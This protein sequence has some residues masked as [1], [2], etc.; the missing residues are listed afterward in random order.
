MHNPE[1]YYN[2]NDFTVVEDEIFEDFNSVEISE[3]E[4]FGSKE[5]ED[6]FDDEIFE[7][8]VT[9][10][11]DEGFDDEDESIDSIETFLPGIGDDEALTK[12]TEE[13]N[14]E[15][16]RMSESE[17]MYYVEERMA[18]FWPALAAALPAIIDFAPKAIKAIK[19]IVQKGPSAP[20]SPAKPS[21]N[22]NAPV[23]TPQMPQTDIS[24]ADSAQ[25]LRVL[26]DL[27]QS[28]KFLELIVGMSTGKSQTV[29]ANTGQQISGA[30]VLGVIS[31]LAGTLATGTAKKENSESIFPEYT[32]SN[33]GTFLI[34]PHNTLQEAELIL[35]LIN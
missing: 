31:S 8:A 22:T 12:L 3:E 4:L 18:E 13:I 26:S 24:G 20:T 14:M 11:E 6:I 32:I 23:T 10:A 34:D 27:I 28:P 1:S 30:N 5:S 9:F 19:S 15:T 21:A 35:D 29:T 25:I 33:E 2:E 7:E 16:S 17:A